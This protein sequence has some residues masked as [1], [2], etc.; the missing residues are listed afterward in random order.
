MP[1]R[2]NA[3]K[4][5]TQRLEITYD[6]HPKGDHI[7][8]HWMYVEVTGKTPEELKEKAQKYFEAQIRSLGWGKITTLK[9][10]GPLRNAS[11]GGWERKQ[12][13]AKTQP[14]AK[15]RRAPRKRK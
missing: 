7:R 12:A 11:T 1:E 13:P 8:E 9:S 15:K 6:F 5:I 4:K 10:I 14:T 2:P 3:Q